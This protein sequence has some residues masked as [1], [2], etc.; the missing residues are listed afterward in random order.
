MLLVACYHERLQ[1][2]VLV[3]NKEQMKWEDPVS[4]IETAMQI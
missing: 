2:T 1:R 4:S 3:R